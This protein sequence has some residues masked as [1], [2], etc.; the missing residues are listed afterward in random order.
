MEGPRVRR[1]PRKN[2]MGLL[3]GTDRAQS[4]TMKVEDA[5]KKKKLVENPDYV[6]WITRDQQVMRFLLS[7]DILSHVLWDC[8]HR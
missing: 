1:L 8:I 4:K 2:V 5:D 7:P 3:D 6:A